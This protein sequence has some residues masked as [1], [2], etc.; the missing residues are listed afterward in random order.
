MLFV[1]LSFRQFLRVSPFIRANTQ[2]QPYPS[3]CVHLHLHLYNIWGILTH[4]HTHMHTIS[5]MLTC[6]FTFTSPG[7]LI[8]NLLSIYNTCRGYKLTILLFHHNVNL[9]NICHALTCMH[10]HTH[11]HT[12]L[13]NL[14]CNWSYVCL[15][16]LLCICKSHLLNGFTYIILFIWAPSCCKQQEC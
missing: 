2:T 7:K 10:T 9:Y 15:L 1:P 5:C 16:L 12:I 8:D 14:I 6:S 4:T 11:M 13:C 3:L